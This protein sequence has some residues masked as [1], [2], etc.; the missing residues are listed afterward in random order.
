MSNVLRKLLPPARCIAGLL[1]FALAGFS[2][3]AEMTV[4]VKDPFLEM[5]T[6][7]GRGYPVFYVVE[8]GD[9]VVV[10][11]R[12]TDWFKVET[13]KET[14]GWVHRDQLAETLD[15][16]GRTVQVEDAGF[17]SFS[18]R[19]FEL[20]VLLGDFGGA[21]MLSV[22]G[23]WAFS[24]NLSAE[25]L[26]AQGV[27]DVSDSVFATANLAH[28][29][30]P[31]KRFSPYFVLGVGAIRTSPNATLVQTEDRTDELARVGLGTRFY[32]ARRFVLRAEFNTY[33]VFT[34]RNENEEI[35][36]WKAGFSF[37]L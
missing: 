33:V 21:D 30:F 8:R 35:N 5:H 32:L 26:I 4:V 17:D 29:F 25:L 10:S 24:S 23:A 11:K 16:A 34:S 20:A 12:R 9:K 15:L 13:S 27:G 36:E 3:F 2:A 14:S 19:R 6:G 7:P 22:Q 37:F 31:D 18:S 1:L 28:Q